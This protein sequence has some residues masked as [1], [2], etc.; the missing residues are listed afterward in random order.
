MIEF[1]QKLQWLSWQRHK[2]MKIKQ[3][4]VA[5]QLNELLGKWH[6]ANLEKQIQSDDVISA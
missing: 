3:L 2:A 1:G 4:N 5:T 6:Y